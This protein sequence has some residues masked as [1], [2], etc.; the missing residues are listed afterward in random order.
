MTVAD[1]ATR[2]AAGAPEAEVAASGIAGPPA[3][4]GEAPLRAVRILRL[5]VV[6]IALSAL[7]LGVIGG[8]FS[9]RL[10]EKHAVA[11]LADAAAV[12]E[13][14]TTKVLDTHM[15]VAARIGDLLAGLNDDQIRAEEKVLH[16][17][18][19][20]QIKDVPEVAAAWVIGT[21]GHEL[22]SARVYPV[23]PDL[24]H[25]DRDDFQALRDGRIHTFIWALRARSLDGGQYAPYFTV[26]R[27]R[28]M[29]D[30]SFGGIVVVAVSGQYFASFYNSLLGGSAQYTATVLRE[31]GAILERYPGTA[32]EPLMREEN[33]LLQEA[34]AAKRTG[35]VIASGSALGSEG[36]IVAYRRLANYPVYV[37]IASSRSAIL[38]E[39]FGSVAGYLVVGGAAAVGLILLTLIALHR[40]RREQQALAQ[41]RDAIAQRAA[42]EA[43]LNQAQKMEAVGLL[44]AGIAHDFN[45]LLTIVSGNMALLQARIEDS[46]SKHQRL[47]AAAVNACDRGAALTRR[48]LSFAR[49]E[50]ID[51]RPVDVNEVVAN[52]AE[53]P[54]RGLGDRIAAELRAADG[55]WPIFVDPNQLENALLNLAINARDAMAGQGTLAIQTANRR[56]EDADP[57][58]RAGVAPGEYVAI[59]VADT[60]CGMPPEVRERAFDPFF[61]TKEAGKGTGLG[62][63][64]VHG[65]VTRFGGRCTI[66]S[67]P[68]RG[69]T[70]TLYLP[71]YRP[72]A[73][74]PDR[75]AADER[76][77]ADA[78]EG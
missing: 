24:D 19:A 52:V 77:S 15:L 61:T 74:V 10:S 25:S 53:L 47:I 5:L 20:D 28:E 16:D 55:V 56:I 26:S 23:N 39:W 69:T 59:A 13:E 70:V 12:A 22:V 3:T 63:S 66:D 7:L 14:N 42:L 54:W 51:P 45:N 49:R 17:R 37:A 34:L 75:G 72:A 29:P 38:T 18:I 78:A 68:G 30:G 40:T 32:P 35:G 73:D 44:T 58:T 41:A 43:Q 21:G 71:R 50:P 46:D 27:R 64:Q 57:A 2:N 9:Y 76:L 33:P 1:E 31:D 60:G 48:L 8:Y 11:S 6:G 62:L 67:E 36:S 65:F 4:S